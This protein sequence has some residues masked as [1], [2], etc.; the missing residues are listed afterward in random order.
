M[1]LIFYVTNRSGPFPM[2]TSFRS[3]DRRR[4][5]GAIGAVGGDLE[6][7]VR[8]AAPNRS[9]AYPPKKCWGPW[10]KHRHQH[11]TN[12]CRRLRILSRHWKIARPS[13]LPA[14]TTRRLKQSHQAAIRE[15]GGHE[16]DEEAR[17]AAGPAIMASDRLTVPATL[18]LAVMTLVV[19][20]SEDVILVDVALE[21][22]RQAASR[23]N[24]DSV[25]SR[26]QVFWKN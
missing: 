12:R 9:D 16:G 13:V 6:D 18:V 20:I 25:A 23:W 5:A 17:G 8:D 7:R 22:G 26:R 11:L 24:L 2:R 4:G 14:R 1:S 15:M 21:E 3:W 19:V 10:R